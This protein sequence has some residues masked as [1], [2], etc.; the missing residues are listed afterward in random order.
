MD[1]GFFDKNAGEN[2]YLRDQIVYSSKVYYYVAIVEDIFFRYIWIINIFVHFHTP[3]A[4][5]ADFIGFSF[6]LV[7][8]FRRFIWN[9]FRLENEHL[10][11]CGDFR[12]VRDISIA[13]ISTDIDYALIEYKLNKEPGIRNRRRPVQ[14]EMIIEEENMATTDDR[15]RSE[16]ESNTAVLV[17]NI[18]STRDTTAVAHVD[19]TNATLRDI[20]SLSLRS[21]MLRDD[22]DSPYPILRIHKLNGLLKHSKSV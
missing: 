1:W 16:T 11:N 7:E 18:I 22:S 9:F 13:P 3:S 20:S 17:N 8:I 21:L 4:E 15:A 2:K 19:E 14:D 6:G 12:A 10:N 5:Y